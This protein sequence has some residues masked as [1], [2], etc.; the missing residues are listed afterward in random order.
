MTDSGK[1]IILSESPPKNQASPRRIKKKKSIENSFKDRLLLGGGGSMQPTTK[2][3][4][5]EKIPTIAKIT[6]T[7][8][9]KISRKIQ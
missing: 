9:V 7:K 3:T 6:G 2:M 5:I 1:T 8:E 4:P